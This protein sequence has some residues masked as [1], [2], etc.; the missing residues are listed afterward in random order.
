MHGGLR[1]R[2]DIEFTLSGIPGGCNGSEKPLTQASDS[3]M[4]A[5]RCGWLWAK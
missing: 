5:G 3:P 4:I 2:C 1:T